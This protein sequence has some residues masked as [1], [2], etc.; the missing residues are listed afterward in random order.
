MATLESAIVARLVADLHTNYSAQSAVVYV[1]LNQLGE[2]AKFG[3]TAALNKSLGSN[4]A[5]IIVTVRVG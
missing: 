1:T 2:R 5:E 4:S 3:N